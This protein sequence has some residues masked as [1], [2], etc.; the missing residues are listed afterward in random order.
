M[1]SL[2]KRKLFSLPQKTLRFL[3]QFQLLK[4]L[5]KIRR[6]LASRTFLSTKTKTGPPVAQLKLI[7]TPLLLAS[8]IS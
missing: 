5:K 1:S 4:S 8:S 6:S 2:K 3:L 7:E